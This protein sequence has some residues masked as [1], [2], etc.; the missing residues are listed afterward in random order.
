MSFGAFPDCLSQAVFKG[1]TDAPSLEIWQKLELYSTHPYQDK[2][3]SRSELFFVYGWSISSCLGLLV[4]GVILLKG[5]LCLHHRLTK[6]FRL[7]L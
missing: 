6:G 4:G 1:Q 2:A 5:T 3:Y 7:N